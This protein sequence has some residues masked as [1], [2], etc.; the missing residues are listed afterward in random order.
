LAWLERRIYQWTTNSG[1]AAEMTTLGYTVAASQTEILRH[2]TNLNTLN[3]C[4]T[5]AQT[6]A[7]TH[8]MRPD[9]AA[10]QGIN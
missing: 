5:G 3:A 4:F 8:D 6:A 7:N 2:I 10:L 9:L 1:T